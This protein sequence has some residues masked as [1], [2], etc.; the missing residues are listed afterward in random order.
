M[1]R[2]HNTSKIKQRMADEALEEEEARSEEAARRARVTE[3]RTRSERSRALELVRQELAAAGSGHGDATAASQGADAS[4]ETEEKAVA[5]Q[6]SVRRPKKRSVS[7]V[8]EEEDEGE[9][10]GAVE[11]SAQ[12]DRDSGKGSESDEMS[13]DVEDD[14]EEDEKTVYV[15]VP[16][17]QADHKSWPLFEESLREYMHHTRQVLVVMEMININRRNAALRA[18]TRYQGAPDDQIPLVPEEMNPFQRKYICTH[19]WPERERSKGARKV[20]KLRKTDCTFQFLAQVVQT[21]AGWGIT[22]KREE[23]RHNHAISSGIY[24]SYPGIRQVSPESPLMPSIELLVESDAGNASI[25]D[26]I[27]QNSNHRVTMDDV[28]NLV[29]RVRQS[30]GFLLC[31]V[32][33]S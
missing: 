3:T 20:H 13:G 30:G 28:R 24:S 18:Q 19:G 7:Q 31:R 25:Y 5:V 6:V 22:L 29:A 14:D 27:R 21:K 26:Y 4:E 10:E 33:T 23:Y 2:T 16:P 32:W 17:F 9:E 15:T 8:H 12:R 1:A 11:P